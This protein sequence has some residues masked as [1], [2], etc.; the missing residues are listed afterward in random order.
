MESYDEKGVTAAD[1]GA[2][3]FGQQVGKRGT[4]SGLRI[5]IKKRSEGEEGGR[6]KMATAA[7]AMEMASKQNE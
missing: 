7:T 4:G 3:A 1:S 6:D 5:R 2:G